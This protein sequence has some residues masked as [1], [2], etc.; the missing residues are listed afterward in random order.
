MPSFKRKGKSLNLLIFVGKL[1]LKKN[2]KVIYLKM[3][4]QYPRTASSI[5][6]A[7]IAFTK[8]PQWNTV[9]GYS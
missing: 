2:E 8:L 1:P 5:A 9:Y 4:H 3:S 7:N 6:L